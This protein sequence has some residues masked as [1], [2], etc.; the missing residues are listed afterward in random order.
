MTAPAAETLVLVLA[1]GGVLW[2]IAWRDARRCRISVVHVAV[3]LVLGVVWRGVDKWLAI[4]LGGGL[5]AGA[6]AAQ[7]PIARWLGRRQPAYAGDVL[8]MGAIGAL[9]GPF[10]LAVSWILNVPAGLAYRWWLAKRRGRR[11]L[12][13]YVPAAPGY[14]SGA[15]VVVLWEALMGRNEW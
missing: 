3:L 6:V 2:C 8:L 11:G 7:I 14:C 10:G 13:R 15:A 12:G 1:I 9:L 4:G 5:G